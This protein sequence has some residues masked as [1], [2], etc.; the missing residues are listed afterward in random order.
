MITRLA[1]SLALTTLLR[2]RQETKASKEPGS[3]VWGLLHSIL[4]KKKVIHK[5]GLGKATLE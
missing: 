1:I 5:K 3:E 2:F 4:K